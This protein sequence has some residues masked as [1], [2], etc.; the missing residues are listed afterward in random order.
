MILRMAVF[1][2]VADVIDT[3]ASDRPR[4]AFAKQR[5]GRQL[6]TQKEMITDRARLQM[7]V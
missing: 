7:P 2:P 4:R 5:R 1:Q 6:A 3:C